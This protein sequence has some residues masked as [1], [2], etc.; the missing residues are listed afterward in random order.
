MK[1][2]IGDCDSNGL[3][4][5][6]LPQSR[7]THFNHEVTRA[8]QILF[9]AGF[10]TRAGIDGNF[11]PATQRAV[12]QWEAQRDDDFVAFHF[13]GP[14]MVAREKEDVPDRV[15]IPD[16][17]HLSQYD[18]DTLM[19][20]P[21]KSVRDIGC[22]STCACL[23]QA[24]NNNAPP[25]IE[26]FVSDMKQLGGYDKDGDIQWDIVSEVTGMER[27]L[28]IT[29]DE[30]CEHIMS[31]TPV[32][33]EVK[34]NK[35]GQHFV[36]GIGFDDTGFITHDVASWRGDAYAYPGR[37]RPTKDGKPGI[38]HFRFDEIVGIDVLI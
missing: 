28:S 2:S 30:A 6:K 13:G 38:T 25:D 22:L 17:S 10:L 19:I 35:G 21:T 26:D 34:N 1:F 15:L 16:V 20:T 12:E 27:N 23:C 11:G 7:L 36:L 9:D 18:F 29:R 5:Y 37:T 31:G 33:L 3:V 32:I 24:H 14:A 8:Q 4:R